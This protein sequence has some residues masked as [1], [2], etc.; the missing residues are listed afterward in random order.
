MENKATVPSNAMRVERK[1]SGSRPLKGLWRRI[2]K[3]L[4]RSR[5]VKQA[6][7]AVMANALRLIDRTNPRVAGSHDLEA[8]IAA[9]SP[10]IAALWHGQHLM[11]PAINPR[12]H[13]LVALF[14]RSAD[15]ELNALVAE[16][17]GFGIVRG[18]GG[19]KGE[20]N[21]GKGG[22]QALIA[23][24]KTIERGCN[25]AM[26]ADIPHGT[27][28][29]AGLG[30][31]TLARISGRPIV[32]VA[33]ATSRRKVLEGTWDKTTIN[34]PFGRSA[35][36]LGDPIYVEPAADEAVMEEKRRQVT[37]ALNEATR[38]AYALVDGK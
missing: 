15:A 31:V 1:K 4:A 6:L 20:R 5:F 11:G 35:V 22:A 14:S 26:I 33:I 29:E 34:L 27:P 17:L 19:R 30:I 28:R 9:H 18:S 36:V 37:D 3:P 10:A 23:L 32:P 12:K 16:K 13:R 7:A 8:A 21:S 38:Q 25:V 24:K 2:R